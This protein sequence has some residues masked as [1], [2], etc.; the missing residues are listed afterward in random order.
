LKNFKREAFEV[1][2]GSAHVASEVATI[3][4]VLG[5]KLSPAT[6]TLIVSNLQQRIFTHYLD[7]A[8]G[9][10]KEIYWVHVAWRCH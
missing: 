6:R 9:R 2:L 1:D 3:H 7:M 10:T 5:H 8:E 4:A